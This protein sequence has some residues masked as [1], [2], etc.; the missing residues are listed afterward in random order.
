MAQNLG[1]RLRKAIAKIAGPSL[2]ARKY[3]RSSDACLGRFQARPPDRRSEG[4]GG[5]RRAPRRQPLDGFPPP[6]AAR[7][8]DR[9]QALRAPSHGLCPDRRRRGDGGARR[10]HG[11][12]RGRLRAQAR[13]P[14]PVA[15][16]RAESD[17]QRHPPDASPD[18]LVR[19]LL[20][21]M[22]GRAPRRG[23]VEPGPQ[24][25]E[26][27]RRRRHPGDRHAPGDARR[28]PR[29]HPCLGALRPGRRFP[30]TRDAGLADPL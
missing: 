25:V 1:F 6:R 19:A 4:P 18:A 12:R 15:G 23:P 14:G 2:Q 20:P 22:P 16:R 30:A 26:A 21:T 9:H 29:R 11:R 27:G 13:R 10:A 17:D 3:V 7:G 8:G 28:P 24:P 5:R